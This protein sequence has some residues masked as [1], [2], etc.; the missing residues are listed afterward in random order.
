MS[1]E[2]QALRDELRALREE[3]AAMKATAAP[4]A[5]TDGDGPFSR[6][7]LLKKVGIAGAGAA[8]GAALLGSS[9]PA[10]A[11]T[12]D[13][14][15]LGT[16]NFAANTTAVKWNGAGSYQ[17][18]MLCANDTP[19]TSEFGTLFP[20]ALG[21][22]AS[23]T[24][25]GVPNGIF[26]YSEVAG[27]NA[28]VGYGRNE[29]AA[30]TGVQGKSD[31]GV[32]VAAHSKTSNAIKATVDP[33]NTQA[34][35]DVIAGQGI[36]VK[37]VTS[38][39]AASAVQGDITSASNAQTAIL[40]VTAG[41]G[42]GVRG[43]ITNAASPAAAVFG[44]TAGSGSGVSGKVVVAGSA[45]AGVFGA[46]AG[47][48]SSVRGR[49]TNVANAN[50]CGRFNHDGVGAGVQG[51]SASGVGGTFQ[52]A[53]AAVRLVP[54]GSAGAPTTGTHQAGELVVDSAGALY[55]CTTAGSPGTWKSV[56]LS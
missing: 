56:V 41:Q 42:S 28:I 36:G 54:T 6:R 2:L 47:T 33:G 21:G 22:W 20:A 7:H 26:G 10:A 34:A 1:D 38:G 46:T 45:G 5:A 29:A 31:A 23:G 44:V 4:P 17:G 51:T 19:Y 52:G 50:P 30:V 35:V 3:L 32:G 11:D 24:A 39:S 15:V 48:G 16:I 25:A 13:N 8:A 53:A 14:T 18:V 12:G 27:G 37:A 43:D 55:L 40:G 9:E 49:T